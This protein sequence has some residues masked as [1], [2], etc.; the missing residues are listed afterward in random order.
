MTPRRRAIAA[1]LAFLAIPTGAIAWGNGCGTCNP[2]YPFYGVHDAISDAALRWVLALDSPLSTYVQHWYVSMGGDYEESYD[3]LNLAPDAHDNWLAWTDDPDSTYQDWENHLYMVHPRSGSTE[4]EA[5]G[6]I[7]F[8]HARAVENLT[9]AKYLGDDAGVLFQHRAAR[10]M[11]LL[12]HYLGDMS[13]YGHTDDTRR[14]HS[15]PAGS[16][17]TFHGLYES[18]QWKSAGLAALDSALRAQPLPLTPVTDVKAEVI[19][20][21][22]W[23]NSRDG[24]SVAYLDSNGA[25]V[26]VGADYAW[27][28]DRYVANYLGGTGL[29][30]Q[31]GFDPALWDYSVANARASTYLIAR[32]IAD[33]H[34]DA[35]VPSGLPAPL[36]FARALVDDLL[37]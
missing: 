1:A 6:R 31:R 10:H 24:S 23:V 14:D 29:Y 36:P 4:R 28:L 32:L 3:P 21:A 17:S 2:G 34:R 35:V 33:A 26:T 20:L 13:Q 11:G 16:S 30:G 37:P 18:T 12:S 22:T 19:R 27:A 8:L 9:I 25:T 5:P 7:A 15:R